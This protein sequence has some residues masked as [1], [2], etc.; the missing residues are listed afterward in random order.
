MRSRINSISIRTTP[1]PYRIEQKDFH[2]CVLK[3]LK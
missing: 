2:T 1:F 3:M